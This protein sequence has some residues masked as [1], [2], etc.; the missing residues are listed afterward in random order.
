M[1]TWAVSTAPVG[2]LARSYDGRPF[3]LR[4]NGTDAHVSRPLQ[5]VL[6]RVP[7]G[8]NLS[9]APPIGQASSAIGLDGEEQD[10]ALLRIDDAVPVGTRLVYTPDAGAH[11]PWLEGNVG[12]YGGGGTADWTS[13]GEPYDWF[14][15]RVEAEGGGET[16][17]N[18]AVVALSVRP[19]L[20]APRLEWLSKVSAGETLWCLDKQG[21]CRKGTCLMRSS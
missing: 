9:V 8:G 4:V 18:E 16:S 21:C 2:T 20:N 19:E 10:A 15:Y 13:E 6:T 11:D 5:A 14:A 1:A 17:A 3:F 12:E 7:T